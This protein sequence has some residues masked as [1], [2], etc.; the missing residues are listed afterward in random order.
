[1]SNDPAKSRF[2]LLQALRWTGLAM[3]LVGLLI[4]RHRI[5]WPE[6]SGYALVVAGI[7]SLLI[8]PTLLAR[9]WKSPPP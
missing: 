7:F 8:A 3:V 2:F 5:E 4:V 9:R 1:M 6:T